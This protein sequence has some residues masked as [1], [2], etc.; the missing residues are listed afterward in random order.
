MSRTA[1]GRVAYARLAIA[2]ASSPASA[3]TSY[4]PL[5]GVG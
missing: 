2:V 1:Y 5:M 4:L 3:T